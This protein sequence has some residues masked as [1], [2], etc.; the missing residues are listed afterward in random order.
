LWCY[1]GLFVNPYLTQENT[2]QQ[3]QTITW[4]NR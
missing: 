1:G 4:R 3:K 2:R